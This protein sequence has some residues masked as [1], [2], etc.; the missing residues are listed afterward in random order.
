MKK[1]KDGLFREE[2]RPLPGGE[3]FNWGLMTNRQRSGR[4]VG[5]AGGQ[6]M[7]LGPSGCWEERARAREEVRTKKGDRKRS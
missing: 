2:E 6:G 5:T 7:H 1:V 4:A 3:V